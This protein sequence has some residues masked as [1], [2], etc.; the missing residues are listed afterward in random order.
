MNENVV[1]NLEKRKGFSEKYCQL[2]KPKYNFKTFRDSFYFIFSTFKMKK[3]KNLS[4][5]TILLLKKTNKIIT[6]DR[7]IY[8]RAEQKSTGSKYFVLLNKYVKPKKSD[9]YPNV[10]LIRYI[11]L[12][13][14]EA[15]YLHYLL[16]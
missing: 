14:S 13:S 9:I 8:L 6:A 15:N 5:K 12:L 7:G 16:H 2:G 10:F 4:Q 1:L 3:Y 11:Q